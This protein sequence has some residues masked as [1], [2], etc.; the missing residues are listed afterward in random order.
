MDNH[1]FK[2]VYFVFTD[3][4]KSTRT[5]NNPALVEKMKGF[6]SIIEKAIAVLGTFPT[7]VSSTGDGFLIIVEANHGKEPAKTVLDFAKRIQE[8]LKTWNVHTANKFAIRIGI[9]SGDASEFTF[10]LL[11]NRMTKNHI[12]LNIGTAQRIMDF[13]QDWHILLS[14]QFYEALGATAGVIQLPQK[15]PDK[16]GTLFTLWNYSVNGIGKKRGPAPRMMPVL[17]AGDARRINDLIDKSDEFLSV[18]YVDPEQWFNDHT[19]L[20]VIVRQAKRIGELASSQRDSEEQQEAKFIR[21]SV[22]TR[23]AE[24]ES[25]MQN[26][27]NLHET[28]SVKLVPIDEK[29]ARE[30]LVATGTYGQ[31]FFICRRRTNLV[32]FGYG[33]ATANGGHKITIRENE[34]TEI[35]KYKQAFDALYKAHEGD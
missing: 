35:S 3:I 1:D 15:Y 4:V 34:S 11:K 6:E 9:H 18:S 20:S 21:I 7:T 12:G 13:G 2:P 30:C 19:L 10:D 16:H 31:D 17:N 29:K 28:A 24:D 5:S 33:K 14:Q 26:F 8:E 25:I 32:A 22:E 23:K 27:L